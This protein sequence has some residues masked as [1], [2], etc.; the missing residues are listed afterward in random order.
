MISGKAFAGDNAFCIECWKV[1][2]PQI[3]S[4]KDMTGPVSEENPVGE[5]PSAFRIF[6]DPGLHSVHTGTLVFAAVRRK[7][8]LNLINKAEAKIC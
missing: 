3:H 8:L 1:S 2:L 7:L 6:F 4:S 5:R